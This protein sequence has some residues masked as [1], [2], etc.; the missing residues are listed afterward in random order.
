MAHLVI[1]INTSDSIAELNSKL[2]LANS[3]N[4]EE[5]VAKVANYIAACQGGIVDASMQVTSRGTDPAVA[6]QG[7]GS[8][9]QTFDLA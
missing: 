2:D 4:P 1:V 5:H 7:A 8:Q 3:G 9:Q 6:T